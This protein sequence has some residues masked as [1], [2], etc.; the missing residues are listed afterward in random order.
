MS[1]FRRTKPSQGQERA[2][3]LV[4]VIGMIIV[5]GFVV[6]AVIVDDRRGSSPPRVEVMS[7]E[8]ARA[9]A[10]ESFTVTVE[11]RGDI[12]AEQVLVRGT[13]GSEDPVDHEIDFLAPGEQDEVT[14]TAPEGTA[15]DALT[16]EVLAW[17]AAE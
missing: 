10:A 13:V 2:R 3:L 1:I 12:T 15:K 14:F 17:T 6:A 11:N 8:H 7:V 4:G 5:L 9:G 16:A